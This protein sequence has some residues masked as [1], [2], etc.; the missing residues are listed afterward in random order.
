[1]VDSDPNHYLRRALSAITVK[2]IENHVKAG[3]LHPARL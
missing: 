3:G 1:M 2:L